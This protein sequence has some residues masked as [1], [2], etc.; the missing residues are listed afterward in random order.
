[1]AVSS[2]FVVL[3]LLLWAMPHPAM[4]DGSGRTDAKV[5]Q[6]AQVML[7]LGLGMIGSMIFLFLQPPWSWLL[8]G[9]ATVGIIGYLVYMLQK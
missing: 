4:R 6:I 9:V 2:V 3:T 5:Q 8:L 7:G 1:M